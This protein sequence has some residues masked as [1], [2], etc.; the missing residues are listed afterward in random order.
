MQARPVRNTGLGDQPTLA[1]PFFLGSEPNHSNR[2]ATDRP[3][4]AGPQLDPRRRAKLYMD[5][6]KARGLSLTENAHLFALMNISM[7]D[8]A[9][10][11]WDGKYRYVFWRPITAIREGLT[12]S[13]PDPDWVS[14]LDFFPSGT[15][16]HPEYPSGH[17]S[18]SG[19]AAFVLSAEFG[20]NT[21]FSVTSD[22][23]PGTRTF[24]SFSEAVA[25]IANVRV[26]AGIHFRVS[27]VRG[28]TLG[29]TVADYISRH[30]M[31]ERA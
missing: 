31:R 12:P 19:S 9:I 25:E 4:Q 1:C 3:P 30:A 23:R 13:D 24:T 17:A 5:L 14:W 29:S 18:V 6:S 21:A 26:F 28:S 8:G 16:A 2:S 10:A 20:E 15:P 27:C 7:A 11:C 22:V